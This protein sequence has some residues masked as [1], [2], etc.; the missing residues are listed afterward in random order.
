M[1]GKFSADRGPTLVEFAVVQLGSFV[2]REGAIVVE[3]SSSQVAPGI[4]D[5]GGTNI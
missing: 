3:V 1:M 2:Q 4:F 5:G